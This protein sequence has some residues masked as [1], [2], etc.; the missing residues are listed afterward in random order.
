MPAQVVSGQPREE[1][2]EEEFYFPLKFQ[3]SSNSP[4]EESPHAEAES[5]TSANNEAEVDTS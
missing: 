2:T 4:D 1:P 5:G 3:D